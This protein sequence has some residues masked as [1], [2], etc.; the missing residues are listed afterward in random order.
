MNPSTQRITA[1]DFARALAIFGMIIVNYKL[2][3]QADNDVAWLGSIASLFEGR[4]AALFVV[5]AGIGVSLMTTKARS[6]TSKE[7][8]RRSRN[9]LYRRAA[10]LFIMGMFLLV[11]GWNADILHYYAV[12]MLV[13][14]ILIVAS[15]KIILS[16]FTVILLA[17]QSFLIM[18]DYSKGWDSSFHEYTEFWTIEGFILNLIFNGFHPIFPWV[19]FFLIG[20][21]LGRKHWLYKGNRLRIFLYSLSG[22]VIFEA[23][24]YGLI[25]GT[26]SV[27]DT[28]SANYLFTTKPMPPTMLYVLSATC[29]AVAVITISFYVVEHLGHFR[30]TQALINTGQLSLTHYIGHVII[31]LGF[32]EMVGYLENGNLS[33][34]IAY[35]CSYFLI[36]MIFSYVWRKWIARGPVELIMRRLC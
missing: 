4:A 22:A 35:G 1:F 23:I 28:D 8:I 16:L 32:L 31:G 18:F 29:L 6:S 26:T 36:A 5:L 27:L 21:W 9:N 14:A 7:V 33:F 25:K 24:S 34:S 17:S 19:C 10:F 30:L 15:D 3:M 11:M 2:A 13:A 12:F 20:L